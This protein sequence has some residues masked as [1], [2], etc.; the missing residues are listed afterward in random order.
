MIERGCEAVKAFLR[1]RAATPAEKTSEDD[2]DSLALANRVQ[3]RG[4]AS[5]SRPSRVDGVSS[6]TPHAVAERESASPINHPQDARGVLNLAGK[7][8]RHWPL[9]R[10]VCAKVR[11]IPRAGRRFRRLRG[12][13]QK[14]RGRHA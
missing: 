4:D 13:R 12:W 11:G 14:R 3:S 10:D 2:F 6:H 5:F 8:L 9:D 1:T 7:H